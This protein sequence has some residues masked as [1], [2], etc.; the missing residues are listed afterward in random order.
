M[1]LQILAAHLPP[2]SSQA[3]ALQ[4]LRRR[5]LLTAAIYVASLL[6]SY[7]FL[8]AAWTAGAASWWLVWAAAAMLIELGIL[9]RVLPHNHPPAKAQ[10]LPTFGYGTALT[11]TC[12]LLL[13]LLAGFLFM[14]RPWGW[15]AWIPPLLYTVARVVD[16]VDGYVA[17]ITHHETKLGGILDIEFD[18]LGVLIAVLLAFEYGTLPFWYLP[19]AVSRQLFIAGLWWRERRGLP[20]YDMTPS[21]NRRIIAGYQTAFISV[22]L[23][24]FFAPPMATV[25][26]AIFGLVLFLSFLRDW[27]V[28][29]GVIDPATVRYQQL[30]T[31]LKTLI[32][33]WLPLA[34][35]AVGIGLALMLLLR[36][37]PDFPTW[38]PLLASGGITATSAWLWAL[39]ML[40]GLALLPY[41]LGVI[42]RVAALPLLGLAWLDMAANGLDWTGNLWLLIGTIIVTHAGSGKLALW[43]PEERILHTRPGA[44]NSVEEG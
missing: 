35:R 4:S 44:R 21:G 15:L 11:L 27:L 39:V 25:A 6:G 31:R 40:C 34:S 17:R 13:F 32:E 20:I 2:G 8:Y 10:L 1:L 41:L 29:S 19:L 38:T 26:A 14:A 23:W 12:G 43:Q 42:G 7:G 18:G 9:W 5:W 28:V 33:G 37:V 3:A 16:Y 24:P 36:E 22:T 30:R